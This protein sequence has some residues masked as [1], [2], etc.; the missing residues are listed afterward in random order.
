MNEHECAVAR[1]I[2]LD[3]L[4]VVRGKPDDAAAVEAASQLIQQEIAKEAAN[5]MGRLNKLVTD[6]LKI[7]VSEMQ[8]RKRVGGNMA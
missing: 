8:R 4:N 7:S 6:T 1:R 3:V 2:A 5:F